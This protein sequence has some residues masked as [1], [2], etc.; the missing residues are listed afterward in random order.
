MSRLPKTLWLVGHKDASDMVR[1]FGVFVSLCS[2][3]E[4]FL[5]LAKTDST[6]FLFAVKLQVPVEK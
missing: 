1:Y 5:S 4:V 6:V 3:R 2:A